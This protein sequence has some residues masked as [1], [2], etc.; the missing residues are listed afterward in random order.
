MRIPSA[1]YRIQ[2]NSTFGFNAAEAITNYLAELGISDLYASPIFQ[3]RDGSPHG[4]DVVDPNQL[5]PELGTQEDFDVLVKNLQ[6]HQMGW[7]QDIVPNHMAYDSKNKY[8]MNVLEN[9]PD[10]TFVDYFDIAWNAPFNSSEEPILA[11]MLGDFFAASLENGELKLNYDE[12]GLSINYFGLKLP[13]KLESYASFLNRGLGKIARNLGRRHPCFVRLLGV[14]YMA[15][16]IPSEVTAQQRQDQTEFVKGLLWELYTDNSDV[17]TFIDENLQLFNGEP[18]KP[19]SFNLLENLL[20]EQFFRLS[21]WKVG[22]EEINY[23]RFFTVN[24]LISVKIEESKVFNNTHNLIF[25]LVS[26][27]KFTGLRIDHIDGLYDP[28]QYLERLK[29][30]TSDTYITVEKILQPGEDL[31]KLGQS[32]GLLGTTT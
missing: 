30:K 9:G 15:K 20:S 13:L 27:G 12:S 6:Q 8:L 7:L 4:Y 25:K 28:L 11:P 21:Y 32:K 19:E 2:F 26:E 29:E 5:N 24:E 1:T 31:P 22:A 23:R 14:L 10:S 3:A 18:G 16:N 17:K